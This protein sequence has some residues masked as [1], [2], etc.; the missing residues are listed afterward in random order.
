MV[1]IIANKMLQPLHIIM[2]LM[3]ITMLLINN[4]LSNYGQQQWYANEFHMEHVETG[5]QRGDGAPCS[6]SSSHE[7]EGASPTNHI[8]RVSL[9]LCVFLFLSHIS[10]N[11]IYITVPWGSSEEDSKT[12]VWE[13]VLQVMELWRVW[14]V[15]MVTESRSEES[16]MFPLESFNSL[17]QVYWCS[18]HSFRPETMFQNITVLCNFWCH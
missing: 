7:G 13:K 15:T 6:S 10:T 14:D 12:L 11:L 17:T 9:W 3:L 18:S 2:P 5:V 16:D 1:I 4:S 8:L